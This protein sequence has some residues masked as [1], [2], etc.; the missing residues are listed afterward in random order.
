[1][2]TEGTH[3]LEIC[4]SDMNYI[5]TELSHVGLCLLSEVYMIHTHKGLFYLHLQVTHCLLNF[6]SFKISGSG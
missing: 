4:N 1:M 2:Q 5:F 6:L 3:M